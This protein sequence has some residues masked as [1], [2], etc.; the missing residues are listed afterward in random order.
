MLPLPDM[1]SARLVLD[2]Q[3]IILCLI[4][5]PESDSFLADKSTLYGLSMN[6]LRDRLVILI[7]K[8]FMDEKMDSIPEADNEPDLDSNERGPAQGYQV[9]IEPEVNGDNLIDDGQNQRR[10]TY[11]QQQSKD[12]LKMIDT[13]AKK[14][15]GKEKVVPTPRFII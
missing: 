11:N 12:A 8:A 5:C 10:D 9:V 7:K 14:V 15:E 4:H 1:K 13:S 2:K 6:Q 3:E